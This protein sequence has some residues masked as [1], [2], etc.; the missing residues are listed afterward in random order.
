MVK[1]QN[2]SN[3]R[4]SLSEG[5]KDRA[6]DGVIHTRLEKKALMISTSNIKTLLH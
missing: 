4:C 1:T 5:A 3:F 2:I 6:E